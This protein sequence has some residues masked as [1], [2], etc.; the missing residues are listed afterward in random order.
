MSSV[1]WVNQE[2]LPHC[3]GYGD[4]WDDIQNL[5]ETDSVHAISV[6]SEEEGRGKDN[7]EIESKEESSDWRRSEEEENWHEDDNTEDEDKEEEEEEKGTSSSC[8]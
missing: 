8:S 5:P 3:S 2:C 4:L 7:S 6:S 1:W